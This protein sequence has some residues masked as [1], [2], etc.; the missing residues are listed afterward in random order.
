LISRC[1]CHAVRQR[2][3][4]RHIVMGHSSSKIAPYDE[5]QGLEPSD[6]SLPRW[7]DH[8]IS[9]STIAPP[10][11]WALDPECASSEIIYELDLDP[12]LW[13]GYDSTGSCNSSQSPCNSSQRLV[14]EL[15]VET[16]DRIVQ[17]VQEHLELVRQQPPN[18]M[19]VCME[20][21][22]ESSPTRELVDPLY[23]RL[24]TLVDR[25]TFL[26]IRSNIPGYPLWSK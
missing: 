20:Q 14:S 12:R 10:R 23:Q 11:C 4:I 16:I 25:V 19:C 2:R 5:S 24:M 17:C 6:Q 7:R 1:Q 21:R 3:N 26:G 22:L 18:R 13:F 8:G 9:L 15:S